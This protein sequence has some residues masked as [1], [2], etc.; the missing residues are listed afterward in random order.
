MENLF[1]NCGRVND[2]L[3]NGL[4][5]QARDE[6]IVIL[7]G[8]RAT[9][10][11]F[12]PL[13][14]SL[15]RSV[16]LY[17]YIDERT[18]EWSDRFVLEAFSV[19]SGG[20]QRVTLHREQSSLLRRLVNGEDLALSAPTSFG[21]SFIIDSFI[22]IKRPQNVLII[23]PTI[24]L[25]DEMRRR[26]QRKFGDRYR[27]VTC[28]DSEPSDRNVYIFPQERAIS[29]SDK[30]ESLDL[31]VVD[32]FYKAS[33]GFDKDRSAT[34]IRA[35]L[36]FGER[37]KQRY[38]LAPNISS[39]ADNPFTAGMEFVRVDFNTVYL[40]KHDLYKEILGDAEKKGNELTRIIRGAVGKTLVY[41]GTYS[42]IA[43]VATLLLDT[44]DKNESEL[45]RDFRDWLAKNYGPNWS[46]PR[47]VG[48]GI[49]IHN[50][51]MHRSLSQIQI[52]LFEDRNGLDVLVSTSSIIEG[53]NT[54]AENVVLWKNKNGRSRLT[55]FEYRNIIGRSGRMFKHFVG[56]VYIL[57]EPPG[58][59][60]NQL[61]LS[62]PD[63]LLGLPE[64]QSEEEV[65]LSIEQKEKA[66]RY[67]HEMTGLIGASSF[68][69]L[70]QDVQLQT[71]DTDLIR[72]IAADVVHNPQNWNGLAYLNSTNPEHWSAT[73][74]KVIELSPGGWDVPYAKFVG[75]IKFL[76]K[77]W[78]REL[79]ELLRDL[80]EF[81]IDLELFFKL[82]RNVTF[83]F[84]ALLGDVNTICRHVRKDRSVDVSSFVVRL[85]YAFL[86]PVVYQLEEYG[87]PRMISRKIH[88]SGLVNFEDQDLTLMSAIEV[89]KGLRPAIQDSVAD[90][91]PFDQFILDYFFEGVSPL[92]EA[93]EATYAR[94]ETGDSP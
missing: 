51:Q 86:P 36:K 21:K 17:P 25:A 43:E 20:G 84:A 40:E 19:D 15:I 7:D 5:Q 77:N 55:D 94:K 72:R 14:N 83:K 32:E 39:L 59:V 64:I 37:S 41:A 66:S 3:E 60:E 31:L 30:I 56:K 73:L 74:Y 49:G 27:I 88:R 54:S 33:Q 93:M 75:F 9:G 29:Y 70:G 38:F 44:T 34:L 81:D 82:E 1:E 69:S 58:A 2:L 57:E 6:L 65:S 45:L 61:I 24:A 67:N 52:R 13:V 92:A 80:D 78:V 68:I 26:L 79:P 63:S 89:L 35:I 53:V 16:G 76:S 62:L 10:T 28:T 85:N 12:N 4:E 11:P 47:L 48:R 87:L 22:S 18:A 8:L 23:V 91:L 46:L 42:G 90:L 50:G 71:S